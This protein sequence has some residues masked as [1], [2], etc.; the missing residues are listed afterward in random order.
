MALRLKGVPCS[1]AEA[2]FGEGGCL[3][4][5]ARKRKRVDPVGEG[6]KKGSV[7]GPFVQCRNLGR[8]PRVNFGT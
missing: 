4:D 1:R 8:D 7:R 2:E 6:G 5:Q 3:E